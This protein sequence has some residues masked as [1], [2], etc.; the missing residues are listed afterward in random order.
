M[1]ENKNNDDTQ[2]RQEQLGE[3][4]VTVVERLHE[5]FLRLVRERELEKE[6]K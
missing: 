1:S 6:N 4:D 2:P 5:D 3:D